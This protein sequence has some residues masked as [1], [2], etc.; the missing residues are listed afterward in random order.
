MDEYGDCRVLVAGNLHSAVIFSMKTLRYYVVALS[1]SVT[2]SSADVISGICGHGFLMASESLTRQFFGPAMH[3]VYRLSIG[4]LR[5]RREPLTIQYYDP[6]LIIH[7]QY[8]HILRSDL[9]TSHPPWHLFTGYN[10][11][12]TALGTSS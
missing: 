4:L 8:L 12:A 3:P 2:V 7:L 6:F 10:P 11:R 9:L 1:G 5:M